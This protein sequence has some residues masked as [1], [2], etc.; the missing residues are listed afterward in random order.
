M[1]DSDVA[2]LDISLNGQSSF[3]FVAHG[4]A[5][6]LE[7]NKLP[8][9]SKLTYMPSNLTYRKRTPLEGSCQRAGGRHTP[10]SGGT[11]LFTNSKIQTY[12]L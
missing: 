5:G 8:G 4:S 10:G 11:S 7:A 2:P 6:T 12:E 1:P 9:P 3:S